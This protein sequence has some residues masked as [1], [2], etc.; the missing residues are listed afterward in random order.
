MV[1]LDEAIECCDVALDANDTCGEWWTP[2]AEIDSK[3]QV[4]ERIES[5]CR[6]LQYIPAKSAILVRQKIPST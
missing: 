5:I 2:V 1:P 4:D 3:S 6:T